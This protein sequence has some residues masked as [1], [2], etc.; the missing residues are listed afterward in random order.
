VRFDLAM[1]LAAIF[2]SLLRV[3]LRVTLHLRSDAT[4]FST[5][6]SAIGLPFSFFHAARVA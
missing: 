4:C 6:W 1:I 3:R 5:R 2:A